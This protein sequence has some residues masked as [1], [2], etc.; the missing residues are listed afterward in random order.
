MSSFLA[1]KLFWCFGFIR[2]NWRWKM[3]V[4]LIHFSHLMGGIRNGFT[5]ALGLKCWHQNNTKRTV[6][7]IIYH[8]LYF[9]KHLREHLNWKTL[10]YYIKTSFYTSYHEKLLIN[11]IKVQNGWLSLQIINMY[12]KHKLIFLYLIG[13]DSCR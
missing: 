2:R 12:S 8:N 11:S 1:K 7:T 10:I 5:W 3:S 4:Y 6:S 13:K 9:S